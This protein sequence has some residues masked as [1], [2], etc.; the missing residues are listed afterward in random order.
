MAVIRDQLARLARGDIEE[1]QIGDLIF[2]MGLSDA[3]NVVCDIS[4]IETG[5]PLGHVLA[6][7][8]ILVDRLSWVTARS[9]GSARF[10][11]EI[12]LDDPSWLFGRPRM[13]RFKACR[14]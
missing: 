2:R 6:S 5:S 1:V 9:G 7:E 14:S 10:F 13:D 11:Y 3:T 4:H 12:T 8:D